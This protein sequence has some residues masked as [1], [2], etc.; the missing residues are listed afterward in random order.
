MK[1]TSAVRVRQGPASSAVEMIRMLLKEG[2]ITWRM[3]R[4]VMGLVVALPFIMIAMGVVSAIFGKEAYK[5]FTAEDGFAESL[6]VILY[7]LALIMALVFIR[8]QHRAGERLILLLYLGLS[9]AFIF[10][11]GEEIS[12]GQRIVGW[13]TPDALADINKQGE[14]TLH[15]IHLVEDVFKWL[16]LVVGAYG[17]ILPLT[18][19][20]WRP[21]KKWQELV[22]VLVPHYTLVLYFMPMFIWKL[23]RNLVEVPDEYSFVVAEFNEVIELVLAAGFVLFVI[24]QL[25]KLHAPRNSGNRLDAQLEG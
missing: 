10:I 19:L 3:P 7:F 2:A 23:F 9:V 17:V 5:L 20:I 25:R 14:T 21:G 16:Q 22:D 13:T 18:F 8:R 12:W 4:K 15:N 1:H 11:I 24:F 6:Q